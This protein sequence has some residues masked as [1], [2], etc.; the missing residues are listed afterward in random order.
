MPV[1]RYNETPAYEE[2]IGNI[3]VRERQTAFRGN[4]RKGWFE[5][6]ISDQFLCS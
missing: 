5:F 2:W 6:R 4:R 3:I 1:I